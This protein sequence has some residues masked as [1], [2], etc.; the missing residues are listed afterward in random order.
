MCR[1][2]D[3]MLDWHLFMEGIQYHNKQPLN[4]YTRG[5]LSAHGLFS[6]LSPSVGR[7]VESWDLDVWASDGSISFYLGGREE[8]PERSVKVSAANHN[9]DLSQCVE[10][11]FSYPFM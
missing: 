8:L 10:G 9:N 6:L 2:L 3:Q 7:L 5:V 11:T 4:K 1:A